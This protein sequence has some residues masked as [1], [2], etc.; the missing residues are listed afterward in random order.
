[1][2]IRAFGNSQWCPSRLGQE[3][4][5]S[6]SEAYFN[7]D[8]SRVRHSG[9]RQLPINSEAAPPLPLTVFF[10]A[11]SHVLSKSIHA[12][13]KKASLP[14]FALKQGVSLF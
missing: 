1:M 12:D 7:V 5:I 10:L 9:S 13:C 8:V 14:G 6:G 11:G 3:A 2:L 4:M